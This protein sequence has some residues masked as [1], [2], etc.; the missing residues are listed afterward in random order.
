[1]EDVDKACGYIPTSNP[2]RYAYYPDGINIS[3]EIEYNGNIYTKKNSNLNQK[4]YDIIDGGGVEKKDSDGYTYR[5]PEENNPVYVTELDY[6][7]D[8][9]DYNH[10]QN[11][12]I[13]VVD[14]LGT[15]GFSWRQCYVSMLYYSSEG[16]EM[17]GLHPLVYLSSEIQVVGGD[18]TKDSAWKLIN[19]NIEIITDEKPEKVGKLK[20][21]DFVSYKPDGTYKGVAADTSMKWR[22]WSTKGDSVIITPM[23]TYEYENMLTLSGVGDYL[24]IVNNVATQTDKINKA[25]KAWY[26]NS[27]L[28]NNFPKYKKYDNRRY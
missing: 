2:V 21:G 6:H 11:S 25:C 15:D 3:G 22:V 26:T 13:K 24:D 27:S 16:S 1:M 28:R 7:Y 5:I 20:V 9:S 10:V 19:P 17:M 8:P 12:S 23:L 18:G 14:L 4:F